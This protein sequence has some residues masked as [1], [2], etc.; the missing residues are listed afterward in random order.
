MTVVVDPEEPEELD[1]DPEELEELAEPVS[2]GGADPLEVV[3]APEAWTDPVIA[4][5]L[6]VAVAIV[7]EVDVW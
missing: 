3:P 5:S 6:P 4:V 2:L 1:E 7:D